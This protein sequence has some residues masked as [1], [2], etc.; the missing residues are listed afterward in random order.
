MHRVTMLVLPL[1]AGCGI[2]GWQ[3]PP[4]ALQT[5][6]DDAGARSNIG[7]GS[8]VDARP[9]PECRAAPAAPQR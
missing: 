4:R 1:L 9:R 5:V 7:R 8:D 6:C 3:D 2:T